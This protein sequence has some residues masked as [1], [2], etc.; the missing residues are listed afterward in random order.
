[1]FQSWF[2]KYKKILEA[3]AESAPQATAAAQPRA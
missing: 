3:T 1:V 2:N